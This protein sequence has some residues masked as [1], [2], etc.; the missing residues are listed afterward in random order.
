MLP[1]IFSVACLNG[2]FES[3]TCFAESWLRATHNNEPTGAI[4]AFMSSIS[5]AWE[6]PMD[7]QDEIID[8]LIESYAENKKNTFGGLAFTGCMRMNDDYGSS[9]YAET[10]AWHVFG[11]PSLQVRTDTPEKM[12]V[13]HNP[14]ILR[15]N[16]STFL[17]NVS[18][19]EDALCALSHDF[20]LLG[21]GYT[22]VKG[23]A[24]IHL[25]QPLSINVDLVVTAY[26]K[27]PY[28]ASI[29]SVIIWWHPNPRPVIQS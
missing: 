11:D 4:A 27:I 21:T 7:A 9:G 28:T 2:K 25:N 23:R 26:N 13:E 29:N 18:G 19:V 10:D 8:L 22:D 12:T 16:S 3:S 24:V 1:F 6:P 17:V 20:V 14:R 5:Q 15:T